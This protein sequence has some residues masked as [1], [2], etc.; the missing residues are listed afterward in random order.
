[1]VR[2]KFRCFQN[3]MVREGEYDIRL[4]AVYEG[5]GENKKYWKYTP[6]GVLEFQCTN[7]EAS[8]QFEPGKEYYIDISE[9]E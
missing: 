2:C 1:M 9:A 5:E 3:S 6:S 7:E 8:K 4:H